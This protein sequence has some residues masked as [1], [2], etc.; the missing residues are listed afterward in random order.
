MRQVD[1]SWR[2]TGKGDRSWR[3][4]GKGDRERQKLD[5]EHKRETE[6]G[7]QERETGRQ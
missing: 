4:T 6:A 5:K 1:R 7:G 2:G 3:G